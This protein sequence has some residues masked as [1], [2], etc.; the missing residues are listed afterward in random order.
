[1]GLSDINHIMFPAP[2]YADYSLVQPKKSPS[3]QYLIYILQSQLTLAKP[4]R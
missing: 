4:D 1:M 3:Y 2:T